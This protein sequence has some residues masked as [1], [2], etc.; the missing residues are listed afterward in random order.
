MDG[1]M[2]TVTVES[3][4]PGGSIRV[5]IPDATFLRLFT[6]VASLQASLNRLWMVTLGGMAAICGLMSGLLAALIVL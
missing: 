3:K 6:D 1:D 2:L 4:N 5:E